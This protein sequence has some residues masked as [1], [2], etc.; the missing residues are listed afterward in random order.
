MYWN[1]VDFEERR[2]VRE[3]HKSYPVKNLFRIINCS[4]YFGVNYAV[5]SE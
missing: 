1:S 4:I 3:Y 5:K 2:S